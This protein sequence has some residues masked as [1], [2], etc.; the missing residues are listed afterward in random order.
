MNDFLCKTVCKTGKDDHT[1]AD[2]VYDTVEADDK[3]SVLESKP[4]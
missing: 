1:K 2:H 3:G 4:V